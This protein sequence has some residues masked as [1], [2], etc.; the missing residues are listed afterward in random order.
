MKLSSQ[1][2]SAAAVRVSVFLMKISL[3]TSHKQLTSLQRLPG[4]AISSPGNNSQLA[5]WRL[6]TNS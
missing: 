2:I 3:S 4:E 6:L 1:S 5:G